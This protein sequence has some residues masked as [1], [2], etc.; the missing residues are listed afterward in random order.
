VARI[1]GGEWIRKAVQG[2]M[3]SSRRT[4]LL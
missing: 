4:P 3:T 2:W 1:R